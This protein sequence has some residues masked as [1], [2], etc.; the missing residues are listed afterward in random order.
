[1]LTKGCPCVAALSSS[2]SV[3]KEGACAWKALAA[4][5]SQLGKPVLLLDGSLPCLRAL[6]H[7]L[8]IEKRVG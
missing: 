6:A 8:F 5:L 1:M 7:E 3:Q 2:P 4:I